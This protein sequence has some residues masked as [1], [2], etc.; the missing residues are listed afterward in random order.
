MLFPVVGPDIVLFS[1]GKFSINAAQILAIS[2]IVVLTYLNSRGLRLGKIVQN[3]FTTTKLIAVLG[4]AIIGFLVVAPEGNALQMNATLSN[5]KTWLEILPLIGVAMVGSLFSSDAWNNITFISS[6]VKEPSRTIPKALVFGVFIVTFL[7]LSVNVVYLRLLPFESIAH[8]VNDRV[9]TAATQVM[10]G[11]V[12][13]K[14]MAILIMISTFGC[15]NG[16]ILAGARAYFVMAAD[17]LFFKKAALLNPSGVPAAS[18]WIQALWACVLCL[19]GTYGQLLD[20]VVIAALVFYILSLLGI[21]RLRKTT[22]LAE[23]PIKAFGYPI[24][25]A[26]Y[27]LIAV[28]ICVCLL[29]YQTFFASIGIG[30][31]LLGIPVYYIWK[32][33]RA[34]AN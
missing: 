11:D 34:S 7:Y 10:F 28:A 29:V 2:I 26:L 8:A 18:L 30:L 21:F 14:V 27:I 31:V 1:I 13:A 6:E 4:L 17:N 19:S 23:R 33:P 32:M 9:G 3:T 24:L 22:P 16:L 5:G 12:G 25:P 15:N 20:Y